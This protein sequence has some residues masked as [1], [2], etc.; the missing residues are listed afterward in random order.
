MRQQITRRSTFVSGLHDIS[1]HDNTLKLERLT[2]NP[3]NLIVMSGMT[4]ITSHHGSC[5]MFE[6]SLNTMDTFVLT[7]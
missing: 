6:V 5:K 4:T 3:L 2:F 7:S 1:S